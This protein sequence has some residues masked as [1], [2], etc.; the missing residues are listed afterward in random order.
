[1]MTVVVNS[2]YVLQHNSNTQ[3]MLRGAMGEISNLYKFSPRM[4]IFVTH[5]PPIITIHA[6]KFH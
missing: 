1:M 6:A 4:L 5:I 3:R 2:V